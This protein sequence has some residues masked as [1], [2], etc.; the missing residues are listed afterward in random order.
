MS[1][2]VASHQ[3]L[4]DHHVAVLPSWLRGVV[5]I[6]RVVVLVERAGSMEVQSLTKL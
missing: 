4:A 3:Q 2:F 1:E 6:D 5:F